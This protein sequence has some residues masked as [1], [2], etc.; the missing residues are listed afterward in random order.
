M[1]K[2]PLGGVSNFCEIAFFSSREVM[3]SDLGLMAH[4]D[5][6]VTQ[7]SGV[8]GLFLTFADLKEEKVLI[9]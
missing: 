5:H 2:L 9:F 4:Y 1:E 8:F 6:C 7:Q 3:T